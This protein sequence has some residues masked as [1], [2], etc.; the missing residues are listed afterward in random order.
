VTQ[1]SFQLV[2]AGGIP[3]SGSTL[4]SVLLDSH[5]SVYCGPETALFC[6][7]RTWQ[8]GQA[9]TEDFLSFL[10]SGEPRDGFIPWSFPDSNALAFYDSDLDSVGRLLRQSASMSDFAQR[11]YR[12]SGGYGGEPCVVEKT[13]QNLYGM[14]AF[15]GAVPGAKVILTVRSPAGIVPSLIRRGVNPAVAASI[16]LYDAALVRSIAEIHSEERVCVIRYEDLVKD[17][18][19]ELRR[20]CRFLAVDDEAESMMT[21]KRSARA[22]KDA[23]LRKTG[24]NAAA[25]WRHSPLGDIVADGAAQPASAALPEKVRWILATCVPRESE[26][27]PYTGNHKAPL[28]RFHGRHRSRY[29]GYNLPSVQ[30]VN[31]ELE[32]PLKANAVLDRYER[33]Y[34]AKLKVQRKQPTRLQSLR[35]FWLAHKRGMVTRLANVAVKLLI[36]SQR[37]AVLVARAGHMLGRFFGLVPG[38]RRISTR[39]KLLFSN[40]RAFVD[41]KATR[42]RGWVAR[43]SAFLAQEA[44]RDADAFASKFTFCLH[45]YATVPLSADVD[46]AAVGV[47]AFQGRHAVLEIVVRELLKV[48]ERWDRRLGVILAASDEADINFA[49]RLRDDLTD[50]G[51]VM[52][53]NKPVGR[54]WQ[55]AV[56]C[57]R[58]SDPD[59]LFITGS[60]DIL[61][62]SF[63]LKN[64]Q[65]MERKELGAIAMAAPRTW[66]LI[67]TTAF[68]SGADA[69]LWLISYKNLHHRMPL[70]AGR[71]YSKDI[72]DKVDGQIFD[73]TLDRL[74]DDR[75]FNLVLY[76]SGLI[77]T[78][79][80][81]DGF[82]LSVKGN[83]SSMNPTNVILEAESIVAEPVQADFA[84]W[85][86]SELGDTFHRIE[87]L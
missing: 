27:A 33:F 39:T 17:P 79:T 40:G 38:A 70:G 25:T 54:K 7:P 10:E 62:A 41:S 9:G 52:T 51:I 14:N 29:F 48:N 2:L 1:Q 66:L 44:T 42:L 74:L 11:F 8:T 49:A 75:G 31:H 45:E 32:G 61:S 6:H 64:V 73:C 56:D 84:A 21:R 15:L 65:L 83:W 24:S 55:R 63:V 18:A 71:I 59:Y 60:D 85:I 34:L 57:A 28:L 26:L 4:L 35:I 50:V 22:H 77:Y 20:L 82:V 76:H 78:T 86:E 87:K 37:A 58:I 80:M 53:P 69:R 23:S 16:W 68:S 36:W 3:S 12:A 81:D 46:Y 5:S 19:L 47:I 13:P 72:L 43:R 67:D 30:G